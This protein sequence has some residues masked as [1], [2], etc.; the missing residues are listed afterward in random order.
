MK[1]ETWIPRL[2]EKRRSH[3]QPRRRKICSVLAENQDCCYHRQM[4]NAPNR[5]LC[6]TKSKQMLAKICYQLVAPETR[7]RE[8]AYA[9][10]K[11]LSCFVRRSMLLKWISKKQLLLRPH[12]LSTMIHW[13][14]SGPDEVNGKRS[15]GDTT[16]PLKKDFVLKKMLVM[17]LKKNTLLNLWHARRP[18]YFFLETKNP[19]Y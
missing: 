1:L 12:L 13:S 2:Q 14:P 7:T 9:S 5:F 16:A 10:K 18:E 17:V 15:T 19:M 8:T 4:V 3:T 6:Y 11:Q